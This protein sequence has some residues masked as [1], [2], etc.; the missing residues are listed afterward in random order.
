MTYKFFVNVK[1]IAKRIRNKDK[2]CEYYDCVRFYAYFAKMKGELVKITVACKNQDK[3]WFCQQ[4]A[5]HGNYPYFSGKI[6]L[7]SYKENMNLLERQALDIATKDL[8]REYCYINTVS[9]VIPRKE[10]VTLLRY[11]QKQDA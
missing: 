1:S 3:Q 8:Q 6:I 7:A 10:T 2:P 4:V 11:L 5:V 9:K